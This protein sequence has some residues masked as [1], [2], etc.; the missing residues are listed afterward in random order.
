MAG[1]PTPPLGRWEKN[2]LGQAL[3]VFGERHTTR[4]SPA[5][6]WHAR[7]AEGS[8]VCSLLQK[9]NPPLSSFAVLARLILSPGWSVLFRYRKEGLIPS[10]RLRQ[11]QSVAQTQ[12]QSSGSNNFLGVLSSSSQEGQREPSSPR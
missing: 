12:L 3:H 9:A 2:V 10:Q 1:K 11:A 4:C 6:C 7:R 5:W 8:W